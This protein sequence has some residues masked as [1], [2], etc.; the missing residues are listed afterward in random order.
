MQKFNNLVGFDEKSSQ[1][2]AQDDFTLKQPI[3]LKNNFQIKE[4]YS[5][6]VSGVGRSPIVVSV[7][8]DQYKL[9]KYFLVSVA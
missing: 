1:S 6:L 8:V 5:A 4:T 7:N 9:P 3:K 2:C